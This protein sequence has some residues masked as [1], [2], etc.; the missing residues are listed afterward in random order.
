MERPPKRLLILSIFCTPNYLKKKT[1]H[2]VFENHRKSLIQQCEQ[3][4]Y[5]LNFFL[6]LS[7][8]RSNFHDIYALVLRF[9]IAH[10]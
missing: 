8:L 2:T 1:K 3:S 9:P 5:V 4:F 7:D 10:L 6:P